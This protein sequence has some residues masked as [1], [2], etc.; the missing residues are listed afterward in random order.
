VVVE[1]AVAELVVAELV[2]ASKHQSIE[3]TTGKANPMVVSTSSTT[4]N[5]Q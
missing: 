2:E 4:E 3:T 1:P 5:Y